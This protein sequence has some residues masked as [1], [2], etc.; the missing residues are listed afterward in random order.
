[1]VAVRQLFFFPFPWFSG[2]FQSHFFPRITD[3]I[4]FSP[5]LAPVPTQFS[6]SSRFP[7]SPL[8]LRSFKWKPHS[9][10][11]LVFVSTIVVSLVA[12]DSTICAQNASKSSNNSSNSQ[13]L[14]I[15]FH[16]LPS[17]PLP[18]PQLTLPSNPTTTTTSATITK[19][20]F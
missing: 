5:L 8:S 11:N 9:Q 6:L 3:S 17:P 7:L 12:P 15:L 19:I 10:K 16:P 14:W 20:P 2:L 18:P 1:V 4:A 13:N